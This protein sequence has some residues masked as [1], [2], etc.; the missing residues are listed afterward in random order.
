MEHMSQFEK[1]AFAYGE[2][3]AIERYMAQ[4]GKLVITEAREENATRL[5]IRRTNM[6]A[7]GRTQNGWWDT[8]TI[9]N[10]PQQKGVFISRIEKVRVDGN[11]YPNFIVQK[12]MS[13]PDDFNMHKA[14]MHILALSSLFVTDFDRVDEDINYEALRALADS[15]GIQC[16]CDGIGSVS[17]AQHLVYAF[18]DAKVSIE[19]I[20]QA[21]SQ[22]TSMDIVCRQMIDFFQEPSTVEQYPLMCAKIY[23]NPNL[24]WLSWPKKDL[25]DD[26]KWVYERLYWAVHDLEAS[27]DAAVNSGKMTPREDKESLYDYIERYFRFNEERKAANKA[28][29]T[30][31]KKAKKKAAKAANS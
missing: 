6:Y 7:E 8:F 4:K 12:V 3:F 9:T 31:A 15:T 14:F 29:K 11:G 10:T 21:A 26:I 22:P 20:E 2:D 30:A 1:M 18:C 23:A 19:Q 16:E 24:N 17:I 28:A 27:A 25:T 13:L 5:F